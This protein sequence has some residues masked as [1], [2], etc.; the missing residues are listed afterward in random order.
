MQI[1]KPSPTD[2][3][4]DQTD[5]QRQQL[6]HLFE[7]VN[8]SEWGK[9]NSNVL[10]NRQRAKEYY[11]GDH[12]AKHRDKYLG[13]YVFNKYA[14]IARD[15]TAHIVS[16]RPKWIFKP[17]QEGAIY[18]AAELNSVL[19]EV[20][21]DKIEWDR[22]G[23]LSVNE[24]RDAGTSHIKIWVEAD[25][26]CGAT[27]LKATEI[28][29]DPKAKEKK[30]L[31]FWGHV[32]PLP[33]ADIQH[34]YGKKVPADEELETTRVAVTS[35]KHQESFYHDSSNTAPIQ[36]FQTQK[37]KKGVDW[38]PDFL[39]RALVYEL[40]YDDKTMEN[41]PYDKAEVAAEHEDLLTG[42]SIGVDPLENHPNHIRDHEAFIKE[43]DPQNPVDADIILALGEHIE[44]HLQY[45]QDRRRAKYPFGRK[46]TFTKTD[47]LEDEPNPIAENMTTGIDFRN[48]IVKWDYDYTDEYW[49]KPGV[50]D[51]FDPQDIF[52]H[53]VNSITTAI[54]RLN[55]GFRKVR[56]RALGKLRGNLQRFSNW[57]GMTVD[58]SAPDD[59]TIDYGPDMPRHVIEERYFVEQF[60][61]ILA[62]RTD[63]TSGHL[64]KGSPAGVTVDQLLSQGLQ[65]INLVVKHYAEALQEM[66]RV[67]MTLTAE[68]L[69]DDVKFYIYDGTQDTYKYVDW[70]SLKR[71][72]GRYTIHVDIDSMLATSRQEMLKIALSLAM[73][74]Y[75]DREMVWDYIDLPN[76][77]ELRQRMGEKSILTRALEVQNEKYTQLEGYFNNLKQ[78]YV[79]RELE[80]DVLKE[81]IKRLESNESEK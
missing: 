41:I 1:P 2:Q 21:W 8:F 24:A 69:P 73:N 56:K 65:T 40:W 62:G 61:D 36:A 57:V 37:Y 53:R 43:L 26:F 20:T 3:K 51:L 9:K 14:T 58:V 47:I 68:Y 19:S 28:I 74:G 78:N 76:K 6:D 12:N 7:L 17:R 55:H 59:V 29:L 52:N 75:G 64:P 15:R 39:G 5:G 46:T 10:K 22:K 77:Q 11:V 30:Q 27:P 70:Q 42:K 45:P 71:D 16:K 4:H 81:K 32:Y 44:E 33:I 48:L 25:G 80:M 54:N 72:F 34:T 18:T 31:R 23:E 63:I 38:M 67:M 79:R 13:N 49:G 60:M 66:A 50:L 35:L